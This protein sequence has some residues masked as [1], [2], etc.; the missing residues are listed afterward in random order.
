MSDY[1]SRRSERT[2]I[3]FIEQEVT[4]GTEIVGIA[5]LCCLC[6]LLFNYFLSGRI[7]RPSELNV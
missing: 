2:G 3:G 6:C 7:M 4:E 5:I 1:K